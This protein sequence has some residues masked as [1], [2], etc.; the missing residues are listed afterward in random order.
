[1]MSS[2]EDKKIDDYKLTK[3]EEALKTQNY[4]TRLL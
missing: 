1:M 4:F 3:R 2:D